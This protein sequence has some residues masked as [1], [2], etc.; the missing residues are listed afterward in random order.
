MHSRIPKEEILSLFSLLGEHVLVV[1]A[2]RL[3]F[4]SQLVICSMLTYVTLRY[5]HDNQ[6]FAIDLIILAVGPALLAVFSSLSFLSAFPLLFIGALL[7]FAVKYRQILAKFLHLRSSLVAPLS[8]EAHQMMLATLAHEIRTPLTIMQTTENVLM[9]QIPGPLNARQRKFME[10]IF[11]NTQRLIT[12]S[13]NML[14][15]LKLERDWQPDLSS[16]IDLKNLI[17]QVS[18]TMQPML[19]SKGQQI[20]FSF[21]SL[22]SHPKA[23][24][25]WIRQV[26]IN[27]VHNA[28][29]HTEQ[30]G[31]ILISVTQD[32]TQ[33]VVT[34]T[35]N[36][37]GLQGTR[38]E[39]LFKE[40]YQE[41]QDLHEYQ[42]GFGLG[43]AIVRLII[44]R[45]AGHVY[46]T[47]SK[48]LGTMVSFTL[49][50][51]E[52]Q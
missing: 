35:D 38:R 12:F 45:H 42:D 49:K 3:L 13:E 5:G 27:L 26:L 32:E 20:K 47:S 51:K 24:E 48:Q 29:K 10:S 25:A 16:S 23:D 43:L 15:L 1:L 2:S 21:P 9:Q 30:N 19:E 22:L 44:E 37:H 52:M 31:L 18:E 50:A 14:L 33:I 6:R 28:S 17:R 46:I 41:N 4:G 36:G 40:F 11:I 39:T 34:V 8:K 7:S